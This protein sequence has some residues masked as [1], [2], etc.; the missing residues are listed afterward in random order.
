MSDDTKEAPDNIQGELD[1]EH[2]FAGLDQTIG[3]REQALEDVEQKRLDDSQAALDHDDLTASPG[4]RAGQLQRAHRQREQGL[5]QGRRDAHQE[6][7][8]KGQ[9]GRDRRQSF[10]DVQQQQLEDPIAREP[11]NSK[12]AL[13]AAGDE[14]LRLA[15][16]RAAAARRRAS[17]AAQ[18]AEEAEER[19]EALVRRSGEA[20]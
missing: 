16:D 1:K 18:R 2:A 10:L 8:D 11:A 17:E 12:A 5:A 3:D 14:R 6:Q 20:P 9:G 15:S 7:L 19:A 4:D 13:A